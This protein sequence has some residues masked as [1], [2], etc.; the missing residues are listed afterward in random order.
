[1]YRDA[2]GIHIHHGYWQDGSEAKEV[3]QEQL[4]ALL[5]VNAEIE[6]NSRILDIGCG[7][8]GSAQYLA[9]HFTAHVVG[10]SISQK[11]I[12]SA[13]VMAKTYEPRPEFLVMD[14]EHLGI[15]ATFDVIWSIEAISHLAEK[16]ECLRQALNMLVPHGRVAIIDWFKSEDLDY[17]QEQRYIKPIVRQMLL[18]ELE[19]IS[20][21]GEILEGLNCRIV[22]VLD[23][24][25]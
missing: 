14:A 2:W 1:M 8:G 3:A 24:S 10:I 12:E 11:Q 23:I 25:S 21:Y 13:T 16:T 17:K 9:R 5:A 20:R 22:K 15:A 19:T 6:H 7:F 4:T 18:P